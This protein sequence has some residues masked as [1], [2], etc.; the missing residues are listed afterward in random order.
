[1]LQYQ[2]LLN[3]ATE[4]WFIS[5]SVSG[6][7]R[8][9]GSLGSDEPPSRLKFIMYSFDKY[10]RLLFV[11]INCPKCTKSHLQQ[12]RFQKFSRGKDTRTPVSKGATSWRGAGGRY[13]GGDMG[14]EG[15]GEGEGERE[16]RGKGGGGYP[17]NEPPYQNPRS[18]TEC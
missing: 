13:R 6:G 5:S 17:E 15:G 11:L 3:F 18:A 2:P 16:V 4:T 8:G 7:P 12:S 14:S 10:R 9:G 1:M